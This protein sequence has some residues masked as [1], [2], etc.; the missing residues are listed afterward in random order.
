MRHIDKL[1][2]HCSDSP[3]GDATLLRKWHTDPPPAGRGWDDV[4]YHAAILN[5]LRYNSRDYVAADDGLI[6]KGRDVCVPG[7]H[8]AGQN[9]SSLGVCLIGV[10]KFTSSQMGSLRQL[11]HVWRQLYGIPW[12]GIVGHYELDSRKTCPNFDVRALIHKI[13]A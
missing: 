2:I 12:E 6:E 8:V 7:A 11:I 10:D 5:G 9:A 1:V 13:A 3:Y 4:G